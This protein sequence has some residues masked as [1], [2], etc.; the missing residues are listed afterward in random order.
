MTLMVEEQE[1]QAMAE[2]VTQG[3]ISPTQVLLTLWTA[4]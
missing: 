2:D 3:R 1:G 4:T